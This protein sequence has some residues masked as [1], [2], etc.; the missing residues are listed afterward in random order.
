MYKAYK[1]Q[2]D[3]NNEQA[4]YF[5]Q[6]AGTARYVYNWALADRKATFEQ[7]GKPN[8]YEQKKRF[9]AL[10]DELC[11]WIREMPYTVMENAFRNLDTAYQNFFRRIKNGQGGKDAGFPKFKRRGTGGSFTL[12]GSIRIENRHIKLPRMGLTRLMEASY[13]PID[14][15]ISSATISKRAGRWF[16]SVL[17]KDNTEATVAEA[18]FVIGVDVGSLTL[19]TLSTG[20]VVENPRA[21]RA[22]MRK[23]KRL[24]REK[25][26]RTKG[27]QNRAKTIEKIGR[28]HYQVANQRKAAHA[29]VV[30]AIFDNKPSVVVVEDL[31]TKGMAKNHHLAL[32]VADASFGMLIAAIEQAAQKH[33][34]EFVKADRWFPSSKLCSR[35]KHKHAALSLG[36]RTYHCSECGLEIDRDLN[37]AINLAAYYQSEPASGGGLP[38]ELGCSNDLL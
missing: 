12:R 17:A 11:P 3:P 1:T 38:G 13:L 2:L 36:D 25:D 14:Q 7:G 33:G 32:S 9:N 4:Q 16:V 23:L 27:G 6:C 19:A 10:K 26:R 35:C 18:P 5:A 24:S 8:M 21:L 30:K 34:A 37:A 28:A 31:N 15:K 20:E 22:A 29:Q